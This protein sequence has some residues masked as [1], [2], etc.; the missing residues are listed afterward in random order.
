M[1]EMPTV[2]VTPTTTFALTSEVVDGYEINSKPSSPSKLKKQMSAYLQ[3][4]DEGKLGSID[5]KTYYYTDYA[6]KVASQEGKTVAIT[7]CSTGTGY[8]LARTLIEKKAQVITLNR[9]S[10]RHDLATTK[11][12][13]LA[14]THGAPAPIAI[15]CDL[16]S[17]ASVRN[18]GAALVDACATTGLDALVNNAGVMGYVHAAAE[19]LALADGYCARSSPVCSTPR[20]AQLR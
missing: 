7:G 9:P 16:T 1:S 4:Q 6:A 17:F 19:T 8:T 14:R 12:V 11:L 15:P 3:R 2:D 20:M 5:M 10:G 13:D 18:A